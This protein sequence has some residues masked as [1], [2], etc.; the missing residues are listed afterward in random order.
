MHVCRF[1]MN[2]RRSAA[3]LPLISLALHS[4]VV[5]IKWVCIFARAFLLNHGMQSTKFKTHFSISWHPKW[6]KTSAANTDKIHL[7]NPDLLWQICF[8]PPHSISTDIFCTNIFSWQWKV[9][10]TYWNIIFS[11]QYSIPKGTLKAQC[12]VYAARGFSKQ[13]NGSCCLHYH[14][15]WLKY[16]V[17]QKCYI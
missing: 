17:T 12:V 8:K 1:E 4:A 3:Q 16:D 15:W 10:I 6:F 5:A 7:F 11:K 13:N 2:R 14:Q 9:K